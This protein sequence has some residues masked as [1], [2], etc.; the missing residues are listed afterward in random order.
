MA[1]NTNTDPIAGESGQ[2]PE[3]A[4]VSYSKEQ[5]DAAIAEAV[6]AANAGI[7]ERIKQEREDAENL[8]RLSEQERA[9]EE[10]R[11][12]R[13]QFETEK[14]EF[15]KQQRHAYAK[16]QLIAANLPASFA[17]QLVGADNDATKANVEAFSTAFSEAVAAAV[18]AKLK[19]NPPKRGGTPP[20]PESEMASIIAANMKRGF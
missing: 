11:R 8:A 7:E 13:E 3:G 18:D 17:A 15:A 19:S 14:A 5:L 12:S 20:N 2:P 4:P 1:E 6:A 10:Q 16:E 9:A